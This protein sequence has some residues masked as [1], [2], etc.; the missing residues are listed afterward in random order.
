MLFRELNKENRSLKKKKKDLDKQLQKE[1]S[2]R[3]EQMTKRCDDNSY[4][5]R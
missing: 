5:K 1:T 2:Y 4:V 3:G